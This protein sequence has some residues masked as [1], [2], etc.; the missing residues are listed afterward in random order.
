[1]SCSSGFQEGWEWVFFLRFRIFCNFA[2]PKSMA[3]FST[4]LR[5]PTVKARLKFE[6]NSGAGTKLLNEMFFTWYHRT[7]MDVVT[8]FS[9]GDFLGC[10]IYVEILDFWGWCTW[11]SHGTV[12]TATCVTLEVHFAYFSVYFT[13]FWAEI[14]EGLFFQHEHNDHTREGCGCGLLC[15]Y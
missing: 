8:W 12:P 13:S 7:K 6:G 10:C 1:M 11:V 14:P 9:R 5:G 2:S 3:R 15:Y 4:F